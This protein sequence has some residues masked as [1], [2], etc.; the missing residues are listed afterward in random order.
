MLESE[1]TVAIPE[2]LAVC[3]FACSLWRPVSAI[4]YEV[5][6][7]AGNWKQKTKGKTSPSIKEFLLLGITD[8][9]YVSRSIK[10]TLDPDRTKVEV[11]QEIVAQRLI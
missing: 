1:K 10:V 7:K 9:N 8:K 2:P 11:Q 6:S 5:D 4:A 3:H